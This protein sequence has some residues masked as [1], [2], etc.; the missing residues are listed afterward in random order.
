MRFLFTYLDSRV[1]SFEVVPLLLTSSCV[2][3]VERF[4]GRLGNTTTIMSDNGTIFN[5]FQKKLLATAGSWNKL[6]PTVFVLYGG[7]WVWFF[8]SVK[9]VLYD[10]LGNRIVTEEG[11]RTTICY[12][13]Q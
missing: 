12:F 10:I 8:I 9:Q 7:S 2:I 5:G 11:L 3:V 1:V 6:T 13:D 4:N